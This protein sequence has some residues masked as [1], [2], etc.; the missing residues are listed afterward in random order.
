[1]SKI[2]NKNNNIQQDPIQEKQVD[3]NTVT[4]QPNSDDDDSEIEY[5]HLTQAQKIN[6]LGNSEVKQ[7]AD[8]YIVL[9]KL[10]KF[11]L[12]QEEQELL[13][14]ILFVIYSN[15]RFDYEADTRVALYACDINGTNII[16]E[17]INNFEITKKQLIKL[18]TYLFVK[19]RIY[20]SGDISGNNFCKK[21]RLIS[22]PRNKDY[23]NFLDGLDDIFNNLNTR[24]IYLSP[25]TEQN[26]SKIIAYKTHKVSIDIN[27]AFKE[28]ENLKGQIITIVGL[29][30][31]IVPL[32]TTN[33]TLLNT[34]GVNL[35]N[36]LLTNGILILVIGFIFSMINR[37]VYKDLKYKLY[38]IIGTILIISSIIFNKQD[39]VSEFWNSLIEMI[40][41]ISEY[42]RIQ[43]HA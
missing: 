3:K 16:K 11:E 38:F 22:S 43:N 25:S 13:N 12:N 31:S 35:N 17:C 7:E 37:L 29:L 14:E 18:L 21:N 30:V 5:F 39:L 4:D 19:N 27:N 20:I 10:L 9:E 23:E 26:I 32:L 2:K 33:L 28:T 41:D 24:A 1:M 40:Q 34:G 6:I 42:Y 8:K 15:T 36:I